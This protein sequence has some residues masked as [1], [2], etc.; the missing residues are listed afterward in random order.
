MSLA[1]LAVLLRILTAVSVH[2]G[3]I[4]LHWGER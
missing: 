2:G 1:L 3:S 4:A